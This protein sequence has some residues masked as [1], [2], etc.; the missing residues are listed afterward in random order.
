MKKSQEINKKE[1]EH[2][3]CPICGESFE[4]RC[5]CFV[6]DMWCK[7]GHAWH[8]CSVHK[9]RVI[10]EWDHSKNSNGCTCK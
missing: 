8:Y 5:K 4:M 7:N 9:C 1:S 6:A 10:G 2:D 3:K